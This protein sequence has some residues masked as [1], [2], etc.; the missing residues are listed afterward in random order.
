M[1]IH[2]WGNMKRYR[3][4]A[5]VAAVVVLGIILLQLP[6]A[7]A[8]QLNKKYSFVKTNY[9]V[10]ASNVAWVAPNG[11][12]TSGNG[13][14]GA[15]FATFNKALSTIA[16][17]G[18]VVAK[19]GI[20]RE[21]H[22]FVSKNNVTIQAAPGAE[23]WLKGSDVV[24]NW[25][26]EGGVWKSTG[27]YH[28]FCHV[29]TTNVNPSK[30]GVAAYPE[31]VFINEEPLRQVATK[32]EVTPGSNTFYV[33]DNTPT[34]P[35]SPDNNSGGYTVGAQDA[36][37]YYIG[38]DPTSGVTEISERPRAFT[39]TG[40][41]VAIKGINVAQYAP[42][43]A[44]GFNDPVYGSTIAGPMAVSINGNGSRIQDAIITQSSNQGLFFGPAESSTVT[45]VKIV[46]NGGPGFGANRSHGS[47]VENS[48]LSGNNAAGFITKDCGAYCTIAE[49]KVTHLENFTF[50]GNIVDN[51]KNAK[52]ASAVENAN[53]DS[54]IGFWCDEGCINAVITNNFFTNLP[55]AIMH[56]V[57]GKAIIASNVIESSGTGIRIAGSSDVKV[58]NNTISRTYRPLYLF[59]DWRRNGCNYWSGGSCQAPERWSQGKG[60]SWDTTNT[61][62]YNNIISSR[63]LASPQDI[64]GEPY[65]RAYSLRVEG[66]DQSGQGGAYADA[67]DML[68]GLD[69]NAY[70]RN[71]TADVNLSIWDFKTKP[72][73]TDTALNSIGDISSSPLLSSAI[74]GKERNSYDTFGARSANPYFIKEASANTDYNKSNYTLKPGSS[75]IGTGKQLPNDVAQAIDPSGATVRPNA[76]VNRGALVNARM[77]ATNG[78]TN[79]ANPDEVAVPD[80]NLRRKLNAILAEKLGTP[81]S[82]TQAIMKTEMQGL[83]SI[84][85]ISA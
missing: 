19:S 52:A 16:N 50:R 2:K 30:E 1:K 22:F 65:Q 63:P 45:G 43:Q 70:Y 4:G 15:P 26:K 8:A 83:S 49:I 3:I 48:E 68:K 46:D 28:N 17:G 79:P 76:V 37:T 77:D 39:T 9:A 64:S 75:A 73:K 7:H 78:A 44:W 82:A 67:N 57:S 80:V 47:S 20:Y 58:Y 85:L 21:P 72:S 66:A 59:E 41:G 53:N 24:T 14:E 38:K 74:D 13:S 60:L 6:S 56:E 23:V 33:E 27:N 61:E 18:T 84:N 69:Y 29:C 62:I 35:K 5:G 34:V 12:D 32:A 81:R 40:T 51:S 42:V 54:M 10:P 11:N 36:I 25:T 31:Q 71:D 55:L